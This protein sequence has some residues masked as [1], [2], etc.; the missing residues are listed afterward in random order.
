MRGILD[1]DRVER[2]CLTHAVRVVGKRVGVTVRGTVRS[3]AEGNVRVVQRSEPSIVD[4]Q[5]AADVDGLWAGIS[6]G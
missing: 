3:G 2:Q 1:P 6:N 4:V 5:W